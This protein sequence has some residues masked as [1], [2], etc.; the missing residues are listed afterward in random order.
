MAAVAALSCH[1]RPG[2][3]SAL[4]F[5]GSGRRVGGGGVGGEEAGGEVGGEEAGTA[6]HS[7]FAKS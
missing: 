2:T 7:L 6:G 4:L 3:V 5:D 1:T